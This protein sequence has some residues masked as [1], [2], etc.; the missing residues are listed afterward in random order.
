MCDKPRSGSDYPLEFWLC[1]GYPCGCY[2][3]GDLVSFILE[4]AKPR[5]LVLDPDD[6]HFI[7]QM[8]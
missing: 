4:E 7:F 8:R 6:F 3:K 2:L 1:R 5:Q